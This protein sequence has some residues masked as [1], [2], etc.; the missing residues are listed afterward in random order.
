MAFVHESYAL[1]ALLVLTLILHGEDRARSAP[2]STLFQ[3]QLEWADF[4]RLT[5]QSAHPTSVWGFR[6]D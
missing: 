1:L 6:V 2:E 5:G 4:G 3:T